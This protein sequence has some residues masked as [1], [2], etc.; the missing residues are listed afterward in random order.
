[1]VDK[2]MIKCKDYGM[3]RDVVIKEMQESSTNELRLWIIQELSVIDS[4]C[5]WFVD[6]GI[7]ILKEKMK[8]DR[9]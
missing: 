6:A 4:E 5:W 9:K 8:N 1:M 3:G 7:K 2:C